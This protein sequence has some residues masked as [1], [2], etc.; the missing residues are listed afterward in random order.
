MVRLEDACEHIGGGRRVPPGSGQGAERLGPVVAIDPVQNRGHGGLVERGG[1]E[2]GGEQC[3]G[4]LGPVGL[5]TG[6]V[7]IR[8]ALG[9][10]HRVGHRQS[11]VPPSRRGHRRPTD[12]SD[13]TRRGDRPARVEE[14]RP[15]NRR[16]RRGGRAEDVGLGRGRH[17]GPRRGQNIGDDQG[18]RLPR[19][20]RTEGEDR[21]LGTRPGPSAR[22][23]SEIDPRRRTAGGTVQR[24]H[25]GRDVAG[26]RRT[27]P[28]ACGVLDRSSRRARECL[29]NAVRLRLDRR[30][31]CDR[32]PGAP[33]GN[34][35]R[36]SG[37]RLDA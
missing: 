29:A 7:R 15:S 14:E 34:G 32:V 35:V 17:H 22:S 5:R 6:E 24:A 1:V 8:A 10:D 26:H 18:R 12:A 16:A 20:R 27:S 31:A 33:A 37:S 13:A 11:A 21:P 30:D 2:E 23:L 25:R 19:A 3:G 28:S 9:A 4:P 36:A